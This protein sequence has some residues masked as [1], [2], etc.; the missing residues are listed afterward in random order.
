M[1][2]AVFLA[3][4]GLIWLIVNRFGSALGQF[5]FHFGPW[6]VLTCFWLFQVILGHFGS[7][8]FLFWIVFGQFGSVWVSFLVVLAFFHSFSSVS[9]FSRLM[10]VSF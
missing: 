5:T 4:F 2:F 3:Y 10:W 7:F 8:L 6:L 1:S 9:G